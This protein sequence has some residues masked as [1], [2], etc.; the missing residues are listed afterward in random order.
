MTITW[1][2]I[3]LGISFLMSAIVSASLRRSLQAVSEQRARMESMYG[4]LRAEVGNLAGKKIVVVGSASDP[5]AVVL[6]AFVAFFHSRGAQA[7]LAGPY[8]AGELTA[9]NLEGAS[10]L[11]AWQPG[12]WAV[13][14]D[15]AAWTAP[16]RQPVVLTFGDS[17]PIEAV[18][19]RIRQLAPRVTDEERALREREQ[20]SRRS[21]MGWLVGVSLLVAAIG[22]SN[23]LL[24][25][26]SERYREIGTMKCLGASNAFV[27]KLV[28]LESGFLG[29]SGAL[30]GMVL[31]LLF[32]LAGF[33][34]T[35]GFGTVLGVIDVSEILT[36]CLFSFAVGWLV[37]VLAAV[38][39]ARVA[40]RMVAAD[41]LRTEI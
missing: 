12:A 18:G 29:V 1:L 31:G 40:A 28:L 5:S 13:E 10:A 41:A 21:R 33:G 24:M 17:P 36:G 27:L 35:Y 11:I 30:A 23:A 26:V 37:A 8:P 14:P 3:A 38:Y 15:W 7:D 32:G 20:A 2:G 6:P 22:I 9:E 16:M 19:L 4:T 39:P 34:G 25:S